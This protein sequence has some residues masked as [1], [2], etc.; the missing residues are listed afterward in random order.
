MLEIPSTP[1]AVDQKGIITDTEI[2]LILIFGS[3]A[4]PTQIGISAFFLLFLLDYKYISRFKFR[5]R[6][7]SNFLFGSSQLK[8][9]NFQFFFSIRTD[10]LWCQLDGKIRKNLCIWVFKIEEALNHENLGQLEY[11]Y[12]YSISKLRQEIGKIKNQAY[13]DIFFI[14]NYIKLIH[15]CCS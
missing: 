6:I 3:M 14:H 2:L 5:N 4:C 8:A 9:Y 13:A 7:G 10:V 15:I 11:T 1:G 12:I